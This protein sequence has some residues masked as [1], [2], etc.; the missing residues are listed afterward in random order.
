MQSETERGIGEAGTAGARRPG[1]GNVVRAG[2][3]GL[4]ENGS[5]SRRARSLLL[6]VPILVAAG[7][8]GAA[9]QELA[10]SP[11]APLAQRESTARATEDGLVGGLGFR[12]LHALMNREAWPLLAASGPLRT[13]AVD[14]D[15]A[16]PLQA[17]VLFNAWHLPAAHGPDDLRLRDLRES[18]FSRERVFGG[19]WPEYAVPGYVLLLRKADGAWTLVARLSGHF[20]VEDAS[21]LG[22]VAVPPLSERGADRAA[23]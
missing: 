23:R 2:N 16:E 22:L 21:G 3:R 1:E 5:M 6:A 4:S 17:I 11:A 8:V 14:L 20:L 10:P 12:S 15:A 9:A 18:L 13:G 7:S 19:P